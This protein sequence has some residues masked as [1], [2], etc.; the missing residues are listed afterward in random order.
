M[1]RRRTRIAPRAL[2]AA[3]AL[4][5]ATFCAPAHEAD[6]AV[7]EKIGAVVGDDAILLNELR[8]RT[9]PLVRVLASKA[10]P[11]PQRTAAE[12]QVYRDVLSRMIEETLESQ[13]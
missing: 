7:V 9:A 12:S 2:L 1:Q 11:G 4:S 13:T 10:P 6:A 8:A 3:L 5:A